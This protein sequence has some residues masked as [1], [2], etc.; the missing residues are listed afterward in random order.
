LSCINCNIDFDGVFCP[1]CGEKKDI[2]RITF[3]S[4]IQSVFSGFI[5]MDKGLLFNLK[6]L[7]LHPKNTILHYISGKRKYILNPIS[8]AIITISIYLF[9]QN[10]SLG[11]SIFLNT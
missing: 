8:Y 1:K 4:I 5:D 2:K 7:T 6:H 11:N 10:Y 3:T 9:L